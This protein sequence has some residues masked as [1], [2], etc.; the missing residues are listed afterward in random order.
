VHD[1]RRGCIA[2]HL[3]IDSDGEGMPDWWEVAHELDPN[4][5]SDAQ[6]DNDGDGMTHLEEYLAG[7]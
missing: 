3:W 7:T 1:R 2:I 6:M 4:D 5:P